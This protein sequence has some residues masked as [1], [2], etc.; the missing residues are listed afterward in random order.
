MT[1]RWLLA[2]LFGLLAAPAFAEDLVL[3]L[4]SE[5]VVIASNFTGTE[6]VLFGAVLPE[7]D[8][9]TPAGGYDI[10]V[11]VRGPSRDI[12]VRRKEPFLGIWINRDQRTFS[13]APSFLA[14][15]TSR[16]PDMIASPEEQD[17]YGISLEASLPGALDGLRPAGAAEPFSDALLRHY[18]SAGLYHQIEGGVTMLGGNL[19]RATIPIPANVPIGLFEIEVKL[20]K[21]GAMLV[22]EVTT[23]RVAKSGVEAGIGALSERRPLVYGL[24]AAALAIV[25]GWLATVVFRRD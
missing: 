11:T 8:A 25:F 4:S 20:F 24:G 6:V 14:V 9:Q 16:A 22:D 18:G 1:P 17:R 15:L 10:V 2:A 23:F 19:F 21:A 7:R 13:L 3:S 5:R 12:V